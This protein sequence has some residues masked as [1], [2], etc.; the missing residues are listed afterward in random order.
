MSNL[1]YN[2]PFNRISQWLENKVV[3]RLYN[4]LPHP[5][6][7][8]VGDR[9]NFR[10]ADGSLNNV[11]IPDLGKAGHAYSRNVQCKTAMPQAELPDPD[12]IFEALLK[13]EEFVP[14]PAGNSSL[15]FGCAIEFMTIIY[16]P[17][18]NLSVSAS[19]Q[20]S[21]IPSSGPNTPPV[22]RRT[23]RPHTSTCLLCMGTTK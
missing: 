14:H 15:M 22:G 16:L 10:E 4:D 18:S 11:N 2:L 23:R 6:A 13:R 5:S 3:M 21:S 9:Y 20:W 19:P 7:T 1:P 12:L 8:Y 17:L